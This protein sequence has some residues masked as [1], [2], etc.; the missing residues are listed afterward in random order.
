MK[1]V[2][3]VVLVAAGCSKVLGLSPPVG[4][5]VDAP[6]AD[7]AIDAPVDAAVSFTLAVTNPH[8]RVPAGGFDFLDVTVTR[9]GFDGAITL[10]VPSPPQGVTV[11]KSTIGS[12]ET[13]GELRIAG[14]NA[15]TVGAPLA[16]DVVGSAGDLSAND[17]IV[18]TVTLIPGSPDPA[19]NGS[20]TA[21]F[22]LGSLAS[23]CADLEIA[24][25]G[26]ITFFGTSVRST[27][28]GT[29][30]LRLQSNGTRQR[31]VQRRSLRPGRP[32]PGRLRLRHDRLRPDTTAVAGGKASDSRATLVGAGWLAAFNLVGA[33][34][35]P[36]GERERPRPP[37]VLARPPAGVKLRRRRSLRAAR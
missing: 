37:A 35:K 11:T 4:A 16:V 24:H 12:G 29:I 27:I 32:R 22:S 34:V 1:W 31:R 13:T 5:P 19:F 2:A 9:D 25:S 3:C 17:A 15:L 23:G 30:R 20:G 26:D 33:P 14:T 6:V 36:F 10:D 8:P 18:V 7:V 28:E 21:T